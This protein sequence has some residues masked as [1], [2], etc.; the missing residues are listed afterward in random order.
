VLPHQAAACWEGYAVNIAIRIEDGIVQEVTSDDP[1]AHG[2]K[3]A[4]VQNDSAERVVKVVPEDLS[5]L[6]VVASARTQC[7]GVGIACELAG[8]RMLAI[9]RQR[10]DDPVKMIDD[11]NGI[12]VELVDVV[13]RAVDSLH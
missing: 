8:E 4:I 13:R 12:L 11:V 7:E 9:S 10:Y 3:V 2:A 5:L 6:M 1:D